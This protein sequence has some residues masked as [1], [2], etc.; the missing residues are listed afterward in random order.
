MTWGRLKNPQLQERLKTRARIVQMIREFFI[1]EGFLEAETPI[2]VPAAGQ[3]PYLNP[4]RTRL[5]DERGKACDAYLITSPEYAHKKLLAAGFDNT[6]E[7][8]RAFRAG[9]EWGGLHNPEFTMLEW[10]RSHADYMSIM[11][12]VERLVL[13]VVDGIRMRQHGKFQIP[14]S[15][16]Q[17]NPKS[18]LSNHPIIQYQGQ[19]IDLSSPWQ[20]I[21]MA[22]AWK[23]YVPGFAPSNSH[24]RENLTA[25]AKARGYKVARTDSHDD[26][27]FK[28]FL[29]E[30]EPNLGYPKPTILYDYPA[31]MASLARLK[32]SPQPSPIKGEGVKGN[33]P[34]LVGG[35]RGGGGEGQ[36]AERFEV[37]IAGMELANAFSELTDAQEQRVRFLSEQKLRKNLGK[38][39][40]PLDED[41]LEAVGHLPPSAGIALG[42]DRL[43][44]LLTNA[45]TIEEV[46]AF[47][48]GELFDRV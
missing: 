28:I 16:F 44:M 38:E 20:R 24:E 32:P 18:E 31:S 1:L 27:F 3:E 37:Y 48:A 25:L 19:S 6:F 15:K 21:T 2:L 30:I 33:P 47:P 43:V 11:Q 23:K 5:W 36:V 41:F 8:T 4:L 40:I 10:Y 26:I 45:K 14:N 17:T 46:L 35:V 7:I 12:D 9:E 13:H 42:V 39:Q 22:E 29:T 34:P